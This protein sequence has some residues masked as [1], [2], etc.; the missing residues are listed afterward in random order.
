MRTLLGA[1]AGIATGGG[2]WLV[3]DSGAGVFVG[4]LTAITIWFWA[5]GNIPGGRRG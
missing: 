4:T 3:K 2:A 1:A 5:W